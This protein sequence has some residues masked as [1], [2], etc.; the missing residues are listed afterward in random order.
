MSFLFLILFCLFCLFVVED[1]AGQMGRE[2]ICLPICPRGSEKGSLGREETSCNTVLPGQWPEDACNSR[3]QVT[4]SALA[5]APPLAFP[6]CSSL[7]LVSPFLKLSSRVCLGHAQA[8]PCALSACL[9]LSC[10]ARAPIKTSGA[11]CCSCCV[12]TCLCL[13][14]LALCLSGTPGALT[15]DT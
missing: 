9:Q 6:P 14:F 3:G 7:V 8:G 2:G 5:S 1:A 4:P 10:C 12:S 11:S 13:S 15:P